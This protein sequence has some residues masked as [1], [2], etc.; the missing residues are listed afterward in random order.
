M[1]RT[2]TALA[3]AAMS[4]IAL[5]GCGNEQNNTQESNSETV[6][7][8]SAETDKNQTSPS[9]GK[10]L[11]VYFSYAENAELPDDVDASSR[12]SINIDENNAIAGNTKIVAEKIQQKTGADIFSLQTVKKY[13]PTYDATVEEGKS[14]K[15]NSVRPELATHIDNIGD[16][17]TIFVGYPNWW[18]DMPMALYT[19]FDEYDLSGKKIIPFS[20]SGGSGLSNTVATIKELEPNATVE[21]G[22][23]ISR[24]SVKD[25][26]REI[27]E[28]LGSLNY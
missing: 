28:W 12:A 23:T 4:C 6:Q 20:T 8:A 26:D 7:T 22:L 5:T 11:V 10:A 13:P 2:I 1:N 15:E 16:Y 25:S 19:F 18:A 14:E 17:D 9:D 24:D 21:D 3:A 27:D